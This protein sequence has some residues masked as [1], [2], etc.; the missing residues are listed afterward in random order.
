MMCI[1]ISS[2][3]GTEWD[4]TPHSEM[5]FPDEVFLPIN[6][7]E[8]VLSPFRGEW[9]AKHSASSSFLPSSDAR[10]CHRRHQQF[11]WLALITFT[12]SQHDESNHE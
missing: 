5:C 3:S 8:T 11:S 10:L 1:P 4:S 6:I 2:R 7:E 12:L 9:R